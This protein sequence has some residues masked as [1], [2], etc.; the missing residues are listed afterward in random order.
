MICMVENQ[1]SQTTS[2]S[3]LCLRGKEEDI[4]LNWWTCQRQYSWL[5]PENVKNS[6]FKREA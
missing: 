5:K 4:L 1:A 6:T 3:V 2:E